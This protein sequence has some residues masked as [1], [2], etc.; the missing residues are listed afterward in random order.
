MKYPRIARVGWAFVFVLALAWGAAMLR[1]NNA[2]SVQTKDKAQK[3]TLVASPD[4]GASH[5]TLAKG[6]EEDD[7][8]ASPAPST[9]PGPTSKPA[10]SEKHHHHDDEDDAG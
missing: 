9:R 2:A 3:A 6:K 7:D 10:D 5:V 8:E 1:A 4:A